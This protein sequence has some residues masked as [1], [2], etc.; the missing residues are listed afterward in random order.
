MIKIMADGGK[1]F[2]KISMTILPKAYFDELIDSDDETI[3]P[4]RKRT[5]YSEGGSLGKKSN[6]N[7]V[8][9]LI[10]LCVVPSAPC[11]ILKKLTIM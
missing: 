7:G 3:P 5:T 4:K 10:M 8:N 11:R 9:R 1:G 6:L 2:F